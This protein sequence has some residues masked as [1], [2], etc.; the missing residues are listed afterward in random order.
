MFQVVTIEDFVGIPPYMLDSDLNESIKNIIN[1]EK[2]GL[3]D[4]DFGVVLGVVDVLKTDHT[5]VLPGDSNAYVNVEYSILT[6]KPDLQNVYEGY[7]KEVAEFGAFMDLGPFDA[8]IHVS[9]LM[10]DFVSFDPKNKNFVGK[11]TNNVLGKG[12]LIYARIVSVSY[13]NNAVQ[14][15]IG[16]TMRQNGLGKIDWI[17]KENKS[18]KEVKEK[19]ETKEKVKKD[20]KEK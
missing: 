15:K 7:V 14:T 18:D 6:F 10:N 12:D 13:K 3:V 17:L 8:L 1:E 16:L 4:K 20:K 11:E 19:K 9:Q 2:I 5:K